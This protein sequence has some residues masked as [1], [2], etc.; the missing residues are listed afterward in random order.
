MNPNL[1]NADGTPKFP[2]PRDRSD[3]VTAFE[4]FAAAR[5]NYVN[6]AALR[7]QAKANTPAGVGDIVH[8]WDGERCLAAIITETGT[9]EGEEDQL[10]VFS[11]E[12]NGSGVAGGVH[13]EGKTSDTWHWP[14]NL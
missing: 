4:D 9:F 11:P 6:Y 2:G 3:E 13:N 8:Y 1:W 7:A 12:R 10:H 14:E 5:E